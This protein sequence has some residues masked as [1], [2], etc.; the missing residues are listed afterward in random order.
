MHLQVSHPQSRNVFLIG[1]TLAE[2]SFLW[3]GNEM[4]AHSTWL[5]HGSAYVSM[6]KDKALRFGESTT[7]FS[8]IR[9]QTIFLRRLAQT[10]FPT[11]AR[12]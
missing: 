2:T 12:L 6:L 1:N 8:E 5:T 3:N 10:P 4:L 11:S 9:T 7:S